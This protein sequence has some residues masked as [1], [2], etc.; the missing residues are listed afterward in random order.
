MFSWTWLQVGFQ[1]AFGPLMFGD[2]KRRKNFHFIVY[3]LKAE[4]MTLVITAV[5]CNM[6]SVTF[7]DVVV[8]F[9]VEEWAMLDHAQRELYR[10]VVGEI[11]MNLTSI[12]EKWDQNIE[13][14]YRNQGRNLS[15][16]I[17]ERLS[18]NGESSQCGEIFTQ[19]PDR[20]LNKKIPT[21]VKSY[22]CSVCGIVFMPHASLNSPIRSH[23]G[24]EVYEYQEYEGKP[25]KC[26]QCEK[27]SSY[28]Y[29]FQIDDSSHI[30]EKPY[31]S[32][33]PEKT[34]IS[35]S[36]LGG[37]MLT[38]AGG[39][40]HKCNMCGKGFQY[41]S[42]LR[43]H[44][45][46]HT[47]EKPYQCKQCGKAFSCLASVRRHQRTHTGEKPYKCKECG[48]T[49]SSLSGLQGHMIRHTGGGPYKCKECGKAFN[50]PSAL[51]KHER[52]HTGEKPYPCKHCGKAFI[53]STSVRK[54]ERSHTGE[55]PYEC[56]Q[57][58][59]AYISLSGLQGHMI[60]HTGVGP[61]KCKFCGKAF[62][63]PSAVLRHESAHVV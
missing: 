59:K 29:S 55:K 36:N 10:D 3:S 35:L 33:E 16:H 45:R 27:T 58:G 28:C 43:V 42:S 1:Q 26:K 31:A 7:E 30:G 50:S 4:D 46:T 22:E 41:P 8:N 44:E 62:G 20:N 52:T 54:H 23:T 53:C 56:K 37:Y 57:C 40:P 21:G 63:F 38:H 14:W 9:T 34:F 60:R 2:R 6:D 39:G 24:Q 12:G 61:Y 32:Q 19:I 13:D 15:H 48:K 5:L 11:F 47:G 51:R 49:F 25:Y 18:E 17:I